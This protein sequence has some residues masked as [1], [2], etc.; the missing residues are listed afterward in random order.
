MDRP[1]DQINY[2]LPP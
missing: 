1:L 2:W